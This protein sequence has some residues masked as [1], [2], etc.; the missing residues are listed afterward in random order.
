MDLRRH[1]AVLKERA[2]VLHEIVEV[3][4]IGTDLRHHHDQE[5]GR[6]NVIGTLTIPSYRT[7]LSSRFRKKRCIN[8]ATN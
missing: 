5:T 4:M 3:E 6:E 8:E 7:I 1:D 2:A